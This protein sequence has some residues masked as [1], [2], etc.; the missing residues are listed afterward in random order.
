MR[1]VIVEQHDGHRTRLGDIATVRVGSLTR[2]G[3]VT[4]NGK[5]EAVEGLVLALRGADAAR[6]R[7]GGPGP[8]STN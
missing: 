4:E 7:Q 2:Y 5:G 1:E 3:A 6:R 8:S